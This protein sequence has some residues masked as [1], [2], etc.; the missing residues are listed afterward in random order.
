MFH[1]NH[2]TAEPKHD[3]A[4]HHAGV[5]LTWNRPCPQVPLHWRRNILLKIL[6]NISNSF[7]LTGAVTEQKVSIDHCCECERLN[8]RSDCSRGLSGL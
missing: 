4:E 6:V 5:L 1:C 2:A 3:E 8:S 7:F